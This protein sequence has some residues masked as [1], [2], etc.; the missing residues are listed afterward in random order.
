MKRF[1]TRPRPPH[2]REFLHVCGLAAVAALF[3]RDP[4]RVERLV[5]EPQ[6]RRLVGVFCTQLA[7]VHK[8][9]R[10]V[11][12]V[13]LTRIAGTPLHGGVVAIARPRPLAEFNPAAIPE[14]VR[15]DKP[16]L[17]LDRI[18]NPHNLGAILRIAAFFGIARVLLAD[19][20]DQA[21]PSD[22][23]YRVAEGGFEYVQ[24]IRT[25]LPAS[26]RDLRRGYRV[27]G[28]TATAGDDLARLHRTAAP[29]A[30]VLGNEQTGLDP[31]TLAG[32]DQLVTIRGSGYVQS[33]N[34]A[35]AAAILIYA[36]TRA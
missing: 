14:W 4:G 16:I 11:S 9:Y 18:G 32:C 22:A 1:P 25:P 8:P 3:E 13:E 10:E 12:A 7:A 2:Q 24:L 21:R 15:D 33:L 19:H 23:S 35:A 5:F 36:V 28:A 29:L 6:L 31:K 17:V 26:L 20:P 30:I 27:I 34:V